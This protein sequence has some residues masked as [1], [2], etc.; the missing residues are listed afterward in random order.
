MGA[1]DLT[2][3]EKLD[4]LKRYI[5]SLGSV[6]VA[7]SGGVDSALLVKVASETLGG[8]TIAITARP[9]DAEAPGQEEARRHCK[10][11]GVP[12]VFVLLD[13]PEATC[14]MSAEER[15]YDCKSALFSQMKCVANA[16]GFTFLAEGSNLSDLERNRQGLRALS[17]LGVK[18]PLRHARLDRRE[19]R[20][21]SRRLGIPTW[22]R[23]SSLC[24][25]QVA[26]RPRDRDRALATGASAAEAYLRALGFGCVRVS[27]QDAGGALARIE[28]PEEDLPRLLE[29][30]TRAAIEKRLR[31]LG[32]ERVACDLGGYRAA[33]ARAEP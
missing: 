5:Q 33:E 15:C 16:Q 23:S 17:Q 9:P 32:F 22:E 13:E 28:V 29:S 31:E 6:A 26:P 7:F 8:N 24:E 27:P 11:L 12:H 18:S 20:E 14:A 21:L 3:Q 10:D 19:V 2:L 30:K 4:D 25:T 1:Y